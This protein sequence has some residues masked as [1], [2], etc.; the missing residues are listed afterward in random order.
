MLI[1]LIRGSC[2]HLRS[3]LG[4]IPEAI[5]WN[6]MYRICLFFF[7]L[8]TWSGTLLFIF[9]ETGFCCWPL[10]LRNTS[11]FYFVERNFNCI[12]SWC[13]NHPSTQNINN[14]NISNIEISAITF[15]QK[16]CVSINSDPFLIVKAVNK[17]S[18]HSTTLAVYWD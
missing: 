7:H 10:L 14:I 12:F 1:R 11:S 18:I 16:S 6:N 2:L 5:L 17:L 3:F 13:F 9:L 8:T 4:R 15:N